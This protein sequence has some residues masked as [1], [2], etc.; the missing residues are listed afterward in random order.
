LLLALL[1]LLLLLLLLA[2]TRLLLTV[3]P[4]LP[5]TLAA[6]VPCA[7]QAPA[8]QPCNTAQHTTWHSSTEPAHSLLVK[9]AIPATPAHSHRL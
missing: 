7:S 8:D 2:K 3:C 4:P 9:V 6:V 1:L 5:A